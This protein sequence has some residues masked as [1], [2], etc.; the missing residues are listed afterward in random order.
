M[1]NDNLLFLIN[2]KEPLMITCFTK[3]FLQF[4]KTLGWVWKHLQETKGSPVTFNLNTKTTMTWMTKNHHLIFHLLW[5]PWWLKWSASWQ[6]T[7]D[8]LKKSDSSVIHIKHQ[9]K[10]SWHLGK[11]EL[12]VVE[13]QFSYFSHKGLIISFRL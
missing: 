5:H 11:V 10:W 7:N 9:R 13:V 12:N 8:S 1:A 2:L 4:F 3:R 6:L